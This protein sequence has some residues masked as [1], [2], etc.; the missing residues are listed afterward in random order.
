MP[1]PNW[2]YQEI[3]DAVL[4]ALADL[5]IDNGG[6]A[7]TVDS[8]QGQFATP[9]AIQ[10]VL[11]RFPMILVSVVGSNYADPESLARGTQD[12]TARIIV[13]IGARSWRKYASSAGAYDLLDA[14]R[15]RLSG[16]TLGLAGVLPCYPK[17]EAIV[18]ANPT[19]AVY[20]CEY[21][22][23]NPRMTWQ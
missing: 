10:T 14:V 5:K 21:W 4:A 12:Q 9:E 8:Y 6:E 3:E 11:N 19:L 13:W 1:A 2:T 18:S 17:T 15:S 20:Q 23:K 22:L 16:S 7:L